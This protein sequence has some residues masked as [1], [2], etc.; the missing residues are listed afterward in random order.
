MLTFDPR[1]PTGGID[2]PFKV[3]YWDDVID[4]DIYARML[5]T[6]P[7]EEWFSSKNAVG[8]KNSFNDRDPQ[9]PKFVALHPHW[10]PLHRFFA[11]EMAH[12]ADEVLGVKTRKDS[13]RFEFSSLP[14]NSGEVTPHPDTQKKVATAVFYLAE[15]DWDPAWGGGFE[16]L[17][18][19]T[20]PDGDFT[21]KRPDWSEVETI[22]SV[23]F[24]PRRIVFMQRTNNSLHGVRPLNAP[25]ARR[26]ITV[27]LIG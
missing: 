25:R 11:A 24:A 4:P 2:K 5:A 18:H 7:G 27:N 20:D 23:P 1:R 10:Q 14:G 22:L 26:S 8:Y 15:D 6:F 13:V 12:M 3:K 19:L 17:R 21:D 16:A 9:F